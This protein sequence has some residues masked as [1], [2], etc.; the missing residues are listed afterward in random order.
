MAQAE[1]SLVTAVT[2]AICA[3]PGGDYLPIR[4]QSELVKMMPEIVK[5][6]VSEEDLKLYPRLE[7]NPDVRIETIYRV[8]TP[9]AA[10]PPITIKKSKSFRLISLQACLFPLYT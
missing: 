4:A 8:S 1:E 2:A 3:V 7:K 5:R 10:I 6:G 9:Q